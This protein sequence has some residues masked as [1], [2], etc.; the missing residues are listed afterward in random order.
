MS[1][2]VACRGSPLVSIPRAR[3]GEKVKE[4][5]QIITSEDMFEIRKGSTKSSSVGTPKCPFPCP[6]PPDSPI[7][8]VGRINPEVPGVFVARKKYSSEDTFPGFHTATD[9]TKLN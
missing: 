4:P 3:I 6:I 7:W 8:G 9:K 2:W 5:M 1:D